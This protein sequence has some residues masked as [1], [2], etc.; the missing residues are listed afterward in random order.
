MD[1]RLRITKIRPSTI[2]KLAIALILIITLSVFYPI[3]IF[4]A[5]LLILLLA[6]L[7]ILKKRIGISKVGMFYAISG[8]PVGFKNYVGVL[9]HIALYLTAGGM[10]YFMYPLGM[11][12]E[13]LKTIHYL[14]YSNSDTFM[15]VLNPILFISLKLKVHSLIIPS[16]AY[17]FAALVLISYAER[18]L[19]KRD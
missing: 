16:I 19:K 15:A 7:Y 6:F 9:L 10:D 5:A 8:F 2:L 18:R 14:L 3:T 1:L 17:P 4:L 12:S 11:H 13:L